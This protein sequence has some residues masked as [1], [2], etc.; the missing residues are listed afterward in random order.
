MEEDRFELYLENQIDTKAKELREKQ[1][2]LGQLRSALEV[3]R[4][5]MKKRVKRGHMDLVSKIMA[6]EGG[7]MDDDA[8]IEFFQELIDNGMAWTLQGCYGRQAVRLIEAGLCHERERAN[9]EKAF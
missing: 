1:A 4:Q 9:D 2:E 5:L 3:Y 8:T 7:E 6:W